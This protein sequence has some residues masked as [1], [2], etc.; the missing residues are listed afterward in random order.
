M[1]IIHSLYRPLSQIRLLVDALTFF[2]QPLAWLGLSQIWARVQSP[3]VRSHA[4]INHWMHIIGKNGDDN[5]TCKYC[6]APKHW[7]TPT[8]ELPRLADP[9]HLSPEQFYQDWLFCFSFSLFFFPTAVTG[10]KISSFGVLLPPGPIFVCFPFICIELILTAEKY[11]FPSC[12]LPP[13]F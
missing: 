11:R 5:D 4:L 1:P 13:P 10:Q 8:S 12:S 7:P 2:L 9:I 6:K 3:T